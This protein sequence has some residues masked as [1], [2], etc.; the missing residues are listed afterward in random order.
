MRLLTLF[1]VLFLSTQLFAQDYNKDMDNLINS[2]KNAAEKRMNYKRNPNTTNYDVKYHRLEWAVNPSSSPAAISGDVT[3][4]WEANEAMNTITFDMASNLVVDLVAQR[5]TTLS[6][7]HTGDEVVISLPTTQN[8][9][10]LDSLT[11]SYHGNPTSSGFGSFEQSSHAGKPILWTLSEPYGAMGWWPCKQDL[12]DKID[13]ID[14]FVTHP[15]SISGQE[16]RTASNGLMISETTTGSNKTTHWKHQFPIP[17]YLI[18]IAVTNYSVYNDYAYQGTSD[19][20]PITNYVYPENLSDAQ[21]STPVTADIIE[22]Y[23]D[24]FEMYPYAS[25]KYGHAQFGW[26]GGMEHTTMTFMGG[27]RRDLIAHE[28]AH[29]W[30]GNKITCGS[31]E[32]IWLNEGFATYLTGLSKEH[33]DGANS[34]K[35]WRESKRVHITSYS[36]GSVF[37]TDTTSVG[38]IFSSRLSYSKGSM[39]LHM[40]RYKLGDTD[41]YQSIKNYLAD[42]QLAF[43]YAL[44][45]NLQDHFEAQSGVDLEE[46]FAD[47][48]VGEGYPSYQIQWHQSGN[49]VFFKVNQSQSHSSVSYFEMPLPIKLVG[50][51][52]ATKWLRL[53]N[54]YDGQEFTEQVNFTINQVQFDPNIELI[55]RNNTVS[56]NNSLGDGATAL[57]YIVPIQNP[58]QGLVT[59]KML[60]GVSLQKITLFNALGQ[61]ILEQKASQPTI[62][63]SKVKAGLVTLQLTTNKGVAYKRLIVSK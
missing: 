39:V 31:W 20:F 44:T 21:S 56:I 55:T 6:Y 36:G 1:L 32:D 33:L 51:G 30:F 29:Q 40:L 58:V 13:N 23:G 35:S 11:I 60:A 7:T 12:N 34:F 50:S 9:N 10:V 43:G 4:Y 19:Q 22:I 28:L 48:F 14:V 63:F 5:G 46:Y 57:E 52:G 24:L 54:T 18:A 25:E 62:D 42:P 26:G 45:Q 16:Y 37:C 8:T 27:F 47:W 59:I 3:T 61:K 38:R 41:F 2:E 15:Q 17:A 53:E 49:N